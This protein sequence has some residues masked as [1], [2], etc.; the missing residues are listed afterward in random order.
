M[1]I[2]IKFVFCFR[3][4]EVAAPFSVHPKSADVSIILVAVNA[5]GVG[6]VSTVEPV[7][8]NE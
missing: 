7:V 1:L 2:F 5:D 6:H 4:H 8:R 3:F